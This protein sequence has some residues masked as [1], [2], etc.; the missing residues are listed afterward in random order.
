LTLALQYKGFNYTSYYNG[1]YEDADSLAALSQTGANAVALNLQYGIDSVNSIAYADPSYTESLDALSSTIQEALGYGL[2]VMVRPLID[3]VDPERNPEY[4]QGEWRAYFNPS[5]TDTFFASYKQMVLANA[6][7]AR[8]AGAQCLCI[9]AEIDQLCGPDYLD[10]WTDIIQSVRAA[11]SGGLTYSANWNTDVSPWQGEHGLPAGTGDIATQISFWD[12]LDYIGIDCYA[13]IYDE[14]DPALDDLVAGWT[15]TPTDATAAAI[16][17][18]L[19]LVAYF[20]SIAARV[21]IPLLFTELGYESATD[22]ASQPFGSAT[23]AFDPIMQAN[24]Y[25]AFFMAWQQADNGS[26]T[27]LYLWNWDPNAAEVGPDNGVNFSPQGLPAQSI[28]TAGFIAAA[29][30]AMP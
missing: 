5:D 29:P 26:L 16:T 25:Q 23:D 24:L 4:D 18:G 12:Q 13:P 3:F 6:E 22:A 10:Y 14:P 30:G 28:I 19:S 7:V 21:G 27:G 11:Y 15:G 2:S 17:D 1:A 8:A 9:G 20:Q